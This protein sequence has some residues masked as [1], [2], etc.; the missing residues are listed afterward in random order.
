M[1]IDLK[2]TSKGVNTV[3]KKLNGMTELIVAEPASRHMSSGVF[4]FA[5]RANVHSLLT[6]KIN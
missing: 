2:L 6:K 1:A 4:E 5:N 3:Y